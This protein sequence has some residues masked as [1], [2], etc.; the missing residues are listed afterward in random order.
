[1]IKEALLVGIGGFV[2]SASRYLVGYAIG[3]M[4]VNELFPISTLT[5][6]VVGSL[7]I[8]VFLTVFGQGSWYFL[9][10]VGF[11]GGF[12]TFSAFSA[13]LLTL[14]RKGEYFYSTLYI[15]ASVAVCLLSVWIGVMLGEKILK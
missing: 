15:V 6:N 12:T 4:Q 8:G 1:M 14:F 10:V 9:T 7:L 2:G 5:V 11:C 13:E 3:G